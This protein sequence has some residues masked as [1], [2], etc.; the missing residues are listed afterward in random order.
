M[1]STEWLNKN[2]CVL[3]LEANGFTGGWTAVV[4]TTLE[5]GFVP[6][7]VKIEFP[8]FPTMDEL[9][10]EVRKE[11][12]NEWLDETCRIRDDHPDPCHYF[13]NRLGTPKFDNGLDA[14]YEQGMSPREALE[15]WRTYKP[16]N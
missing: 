15:H 16:E 6:V 2:T 3:R 12:L 8:H 13:N 11:T 7:E 5:K 14:L 9:A 10:E 4:T 1:T